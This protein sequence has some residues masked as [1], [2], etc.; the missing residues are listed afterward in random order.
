MWLV[1]CFAPCGL[2]Q[3]TATHKHKKSP[4]IVVLVRLHITKLIKSYLNLFFFFLFSLVNLK[5]VTNLL[6]IVML[7]LR[8]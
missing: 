3:F 8:I 2:D 7:T 5:L 6:A 1:V 4:E